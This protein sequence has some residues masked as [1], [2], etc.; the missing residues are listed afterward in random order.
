MKVSG[1]NVCPNCGERVTMFAAG[2][3]ICGESLD[4]HRAEAPA[5]RRLLARIRRIRARQ[6]ATARAIR[7]R[8]R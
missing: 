1:P 7:P 8:P 5:L 4:P 2:C 6:P 3:S